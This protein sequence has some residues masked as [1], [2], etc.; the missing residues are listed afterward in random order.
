[1]FVRIIKSYRN[2]AV[3]CDEDLIGKNFEDGEFKLYVKED[4]YKGD[5]VSKQ[6]AAEIMKEMSRED[7]TFNIV[8]KESINTA[9]ESEIIS[10]DS[11]K[12]IQGVPYAMVL[13]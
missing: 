1:M 6:R 8:G 13:L 9:I 12:E 11:V 5:S 2:V 7:A 3:V 10:P 4:F